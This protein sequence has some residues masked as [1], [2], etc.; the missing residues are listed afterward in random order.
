MSTTQSKYESASSGAKPAGGAMVKKAAQRK[1]SNQGETARP[2][3]T[4]ELDAIQLLMSDHRE[5]EAM[6]EHF[7]Q[8][9]DEDEKM[10]IAEN[11]CLALLVHT[12]I[13]EEIFYPAFRKAT[14]DDDMTDEAI[15][16]H[17]AAKDLI[18]QIEAMEPEED[19]YD[20]KV[21][22]LSEEIEH[23]VEEE[24]DEDGMFAE[25]KKS[26]MDLKALGKQMAERKAQ[27]MQELAGD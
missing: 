4:P 7:E 22:V 24:E 21:K 12:Q 23:H 6:F 13:E 8:T 17:A 25:A 10:E 15:V 1:A 19:L 27:L 18:E 20:A 3:E 5:V 16:E 26:D 11:I 9:D 14:G 2:A